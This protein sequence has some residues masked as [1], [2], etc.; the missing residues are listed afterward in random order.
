MGRT[1]AAAPWAQRC[2][3]TA[4]PD[5]APPDTALPDRAP[6][7]AERRGRW[8]RTARLLGRAA[9]RKATRRTAR[10]WAGRRALRRERGTGF[11]TERHSARRPASALRRRAVAWGTAPAPTLRRYSPIPLPAIRAIRFS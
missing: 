1:S 4:S 3:D 8:V 5:R 11:H 2:Q 6:E 9:C 7:Q 10:P